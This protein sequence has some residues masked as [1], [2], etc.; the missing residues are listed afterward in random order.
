MQTLIWILAVLLVSI[1]AYLLSYLRF[2]RMIAQQT[3]QMIALMKAENIEQMQIGNIYSQTDEDF[4]HLERAALSLRRKYLL[5]KKRS[6]EERA[7][8]ESVFSGLKEAIVTVDK[9]LKVISFNDSFMRCFSWAPSKDV[10]H[11]FLQDI[12]RDPQ[13]IETFKKTFTTSQ[14]QKTEV[15]RFQ[16]FVT[17]LPSL[18]E[19]ESWC[20]G[21]FYDLTELRKTEKIRIDFVANASHEIRTPL[22]VVK[23]YAEVLNQSLKQKNLQHELDLLEPILQST[24]QMSDLM[25]QLL[26]LSRI[27]V[28][29][30]LTKESISTKEITDA[31]MEDIDNI[32]KLNSKKINVSYETDRVLG[33][34]EAI[35]QILRNLIVNAV[36][37]SGNTSDIEINWKLNSGK[38]LLYV[39]DFGLGI[40]KEHQDRI[41]E[42][43]YRVDKGRNRDQGGS[44]LGL[45]LV[46]HYVLGHGGQVKLNSDI[47]KGCEFICEFP[48]E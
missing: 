37:Y 43:F 31:V 25:D 24:E 40:A 17:Q 21:V 14:V 11:Y 13:I 15:S 38:V 26:N 22:T 9:N 46:K 30:V 19:A 18:N 44:G 48:I 20:L 10:H 4:S 27:E 5:L 42:R 7:G 35:K 47:G 28:G 36:K 12:I 34:A 6:T 41:F 2:R 16:L 45:A 32:R 33:N 8:Y 1:A 39:K 23:G 3:Q 29:S